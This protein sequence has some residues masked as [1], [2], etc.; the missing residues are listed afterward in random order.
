MTEHTKLARFVTRVRKARE[1]R[2]VAREERQAQRFERQKTRLERE[3]EIEERRAKVRKFQEVSRPKG[4]PT[5]VGFGQRFVQAQQSF[6]PSPRA[7]ARKRKKVKRI[8]QPQM[9]VDQ[10]GRPVQVVKRVAKRKIK[11]KQAPQ[12]QSPFAPTFGL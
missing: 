7:T 6:F 1:G 3:G 8:A 5:G 12:Q 4:A 2:A 9:F 11:K 10:F